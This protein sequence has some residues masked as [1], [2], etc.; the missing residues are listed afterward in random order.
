MTMYRSQ[1]L[2]LKYL[3]AALVLFGVMILAGLLSAWYYVRPDLLFGILH[4]NIAKILHIDTMIIW[5][6]MGFMGAIYWFLPEE[7]GRELGGI[8][9]A[10]IMF[11]VFCA[12]VAVVA[13]I[14]ILVQYGSSDETSLWLINQGRKYV[15]A[16]RW[17]ALGVTV[18]ITVF[19]NNVLG[20]AYA[21]HNIT[22]ITA[23]LMIDLVPLL[24]LYLI[25]F[26]SISNMS[27]DL[28]CWW[29]LVHLWVE[30]TWEVLIAC[31]M[32]FALMQLL[33][34]SRRIVE[35][36]LYI[37]VALVLGTGILG[38]GHHYFWIGTPSYW[39]A[40]GGFFSAL[41]PLPLLGMVIHAIYDA[42]KHHM[43]TTNRPAFYWMLAEAEISSAQACGAS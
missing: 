17:A 15:E 27:V 1:V 32:A 40:I 9:A 41:E 31:I 28:F 3:A 12:T 4:F 10:E 37:E 36:W 30:A 19:A 6:L 35:T 8:K 14:F 33:A 39:L 29:W 42:G 13:I 34:T 7:F 20:T 16:P 5:L 22:G 43:K 2:A 21:A 26:P 24:A 25:A 23:V 18:V 11:Y 38:L